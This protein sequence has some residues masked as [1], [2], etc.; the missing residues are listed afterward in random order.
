MEE[1]RIH[2]LSGDG[3]MPS[4]FDSLITA[5]PVLQ[6]AE[7]VMPY[8]GAIALLVAALSLAII[9]Q[10]ALFAPTATNPDSRRAR[11]EE[12]SRRRRGEL[13]DLAIA[14]DG[15]LDKWDR[16]WRRELPPTVYVSL[17]QAETDPPNLAAEEGGLD[18]TLAEV[19]T[20]CCAGCGTEL[21]DNDTRFE[22]GSGWPCFF[23]CL[24][25]AVRERHDLD[26]ERMELICN[27]CNG[28]LGHIFRDEGWALPP[29]AERHCV[30]SRS[31]RFVPAT[32]E[33]VMAREVAAKAAEV[34]AEDAEWEDAAVDVM[35]EID[36]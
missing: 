24:P 5:S 7:D 1:G 16:V 19:G 10:N 36:D 8:G 12:N 23:T 21:Y 25:G 27:A 30:N 34:E 26:G 4:L 22:A 28:H 20:L 17:R 35:D 18:D 31:L 3:S 32:P 33:E 13:C 29:P 14:H 11:R 2:Q 9:I 15:S 6:A